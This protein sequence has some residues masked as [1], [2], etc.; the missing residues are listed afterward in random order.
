MLVTITVSVGKQEKVLEFVERPVVVCM[1]SS[2]M[3]ACQ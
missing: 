1:W 3:I 2:S